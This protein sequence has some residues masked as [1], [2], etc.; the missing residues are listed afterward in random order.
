MLRLPSEGFSREGAGG[1]VV[2]RDEVRHPVEVGGR[3]LRGDTPDRNIEPLADGL[4]DGAHGDALLG[5][6]VKT[7]AGSGL[8][9]GEPVQTS[10][11]EPMDGGPA[12]R[13]VSDVGGEPLLPGDLDEERDEAVVT[14]A[15]DGGREAD[16]AGPHAARRG[17]RTR[18]SAGARGW[19]WPSVGR[20]SFSV[21]RRPGASSAVPE[22]ETKGLPEPSSARLMAGRAVRSVSLAWA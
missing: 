18:S 21:A 2:D 16:D 4:G 8:L 1:R 22:V 5:D 12:I 19:T 20:A 9:E 3:I 14:A 10:R 13:A 6:C 15:V 11:V 17:R 7:S